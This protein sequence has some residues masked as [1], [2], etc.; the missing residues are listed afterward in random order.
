MSMDSLT[1]KINKD[2]RDSESEDIPMPNHRD[3]FDPNS[4][5]VNTHDFMRENQER[6]SN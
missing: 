2:S 6:L 3:T 1:I 4:F 5:F